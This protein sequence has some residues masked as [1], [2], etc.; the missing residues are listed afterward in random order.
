[1][2]FS[3][4]GRL[5]RERKFYQAQGVNEGKRKDRGGVGQRKSLLIFPLPHP[6]PSDMAV[7]RL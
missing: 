5:E 6:L 4:S 3:G 2:N 7:A 1:L